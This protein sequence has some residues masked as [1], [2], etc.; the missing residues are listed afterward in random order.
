MSTPLLGL[1]MCPEKN[2]ESAQ[3]CIKFSARWVKLWEYLW[4]N[5]DRLM[6]FLRTMLVK[7]ATPGVKMAS[8]PRP[9]ISSSRLRVASIRNRGS[10]TFTTS[11]YY[12]DNNSNSSRIISSTIILNCKLNWHFFPKKNCRTVVLQSYKRVNWD[13]MGLGSHW[14]LVRFPT[15]FLE[16]MLVY[17]SWRTW[18]GVGYKSP[19]RWSSEP[20]L[21]QLSCLPP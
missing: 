21:S 13:G 5:W 8:T 15:Y 14:L 18:L 9:R 19:A 20:W 3:S 16:V 11:S 10:F 1:D 7:S 2:T 12:S 6:R 17:V 4:R